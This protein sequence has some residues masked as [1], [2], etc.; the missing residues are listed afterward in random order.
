MTWRRTVAGTVMTLAGTT[1]GLVNSTRT[2]LGD[3]IGSVDAVADLSSGGLVE[4]ADYAAFGAMR[5][6]LSAVV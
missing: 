2:L 3:Q 4:R 6:A 1:A 5:T